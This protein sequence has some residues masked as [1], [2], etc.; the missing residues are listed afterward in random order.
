[1]GDDFRTTRWSVVRAAGADDATRRDALGWLCEAYWF[2]L[3]AFARRRG[4]SED[5][6]RDAVQAF[7]AHVLEKDAL[8]GLSPAAGKF[9][10]FLL[11]SFK[12]FLSNERARAA[13]EK[14][15]ATQ[16][17]FTVSLDDAEDIYRREATDGLDAEQLYERRWALA[18]VLGATAKLRREFEAAGRGH[19]FVAL[20]PYLSGESDRTYAETG[21]R[22]DM[23]AGAIKT[24]IHRLRKR[25]GAVLREEVAETVTEPEDVEDELRHLL[26]VLG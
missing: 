20:Q 8:T 6:A 9:R 7:F 24:A 1:M 23:S 13:A 10:A 5:D 2:P 26:R 18:V 4:R 15:R 17:A 11:A 21:A 14:R 12:K 3:Y 16:A 25:L 22:L 19:V